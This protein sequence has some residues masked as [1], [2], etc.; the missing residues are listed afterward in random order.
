MGAS[1]LAACGQT[2][3][4]Y[5]LV[6]LG[7]ANTES[8]FAGSGPVINE[9]GVVV[10]GDPVGL[11]VWRQ[12]VIEYVP[13]SSDGSFAMDISDRGDIVGQSREGAPLA[14]IDGEAVDLDSIVPQRVTLVTAVNEKGEFLVQTIEAKSYFVQGG[15]AIQIG[16]DEDRV[17]AE[18]LNDSGF[19]VGRFYTGSGDFMPFLW[20]GDH[21]IPLFRSEGGASAISQA[22]VVCGS[23]TVQ[24]PETQA[25]LFAGGEI[26]F[27]EPIPGADMNAPLAVGDDG[28]AVGVVRLDGG[29]F[30]AAIWRNGQGAHLQGLIRNDPGWVLEQA[31]DLN[32]RG[33]IVGIAVEPDTGTPHAVLLNPWKRPRLSQ[34]HP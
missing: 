7:I 19:V 25:F 10:Y 4:A 11:A 6:D 2:A 14:W 26:E 28:V 30:R 31:S 18:G 24:F 20:S 9:S 27:A 15:L 34:Q 22:G 32:A 12:G 13:D 21:A 16:G 23:R 17:L 1:P 29:G 33:Q 3:L 8:T 5:D